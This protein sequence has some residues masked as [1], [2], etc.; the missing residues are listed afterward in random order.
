MKIYKMSP[1]NRRFQGIKIH[2]FENR[3]FLATLYV[4][5]AFFGRNEGKWR[6]MAREK[7]KK[8]EEKE[9]HERKSREKIAK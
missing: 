5:E 2:H 4:L 7:E 9:E 6:Q 1:I 3:T 8:S